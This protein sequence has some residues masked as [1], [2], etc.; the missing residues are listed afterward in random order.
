MRHVQQT[1]HSNLP[2]AAFAS[3]TGLSGSYLEKLFKANTGLPLT[4]Y[5]LRY[6]VYLASI[7][8]GMGFSI[9]DAALRAGFSSSSHFSRTYRALTGD[10]ASR[11]LLKPA[12][13]ILLERKVI[14]RILPLARG[15]SD[16]EG[17]YQGTHVTHG[18]PGDRGVAPGS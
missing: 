8:L 4:R 11:M 7:L 17:Q 5:R 13:E 3:E 15:K 1:A 6:R 16:A 10:T 2:L 14:R 18:I 9:T 12:A